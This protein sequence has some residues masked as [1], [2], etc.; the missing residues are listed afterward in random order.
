MPSQVY[1]TQYANEKRHAAV[2][3]IEKPPFVFTSGGFP[4]LY[5]YRIYIF[6]VLRL[7]SEPRL[8]HM[9]ISR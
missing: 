1:D 3:S 4:N 8:N 7:M 5:F 2:Y 9:R 6:S